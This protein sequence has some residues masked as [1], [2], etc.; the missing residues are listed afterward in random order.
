MIDNIDIVCFLAFNLGIK[1]CCTV[2]GPAMM[3]HTDRNAI[4]DLGSHTNRPII[5][6][7]RI[8][9]SYQII[10]EAQVVIS[11]K[12]GMKEKKY[13]GSSDHPRT[14]RAAA[15]EGFLTPNQGNQSVYQGTFN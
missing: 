1:A 11:L 2:L 9:H 14:I 5:M 8:G 3:S 6:D 12:R 7:T 13:E 15:L 4:I 10:D